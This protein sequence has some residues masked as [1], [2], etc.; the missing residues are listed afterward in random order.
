[1]FSINI[2]ALVAS[3][4]SGRVAARYKARPAALVGML[5]L[6]LGWASLIVLHRSLLLFVPGAVLCS[7]GLAF[8]S[9]ALYNQIVEAKPAHQ[10]GEAT[11]MLYVFF[12]C[13]FAVGAQAVFALLRSATAGHD[14]ASFPADTGY[15]SVFVYIA[16]SSIAGLLVAFMLPK[17][18][19]H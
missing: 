17:R 3:P 4:W 9:T 7:F 1:M 11:G 16:C 8:A 12:S 6:A 15:V 10:T 19:T 13:F 14:G 5:I 18:R 2:V